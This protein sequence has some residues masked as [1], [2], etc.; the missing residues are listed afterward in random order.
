MSARWEHLTSADVT[1]YIGPEWSIE[2]LY[3][4]VKQKSHHHLPGHVPEPSTG[5]AFQAARCLQL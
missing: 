3:Q 5:Q 4:S 1:R 2:L